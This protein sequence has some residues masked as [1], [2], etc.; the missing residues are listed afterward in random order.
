[1]TQR[2]DEQYHFLE[3]QP[4]IAIIKHVYWKGK[5]NILV[6]RGDEVQGQVKFFMDNT[7]IY[8]WVIPFYVSCCAY[9]PSEDRCLRVSH[10]LY[11]A[12]MEWH[13]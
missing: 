10:L 7:Q 2:K 13:F 3:L 4:L 6:E 9:G 5:C 1:M 12:M 11:K 8:N